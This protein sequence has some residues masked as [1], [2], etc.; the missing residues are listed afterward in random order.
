MNWNNRQGNY[1]SVVMQC[2]Q[3]FIRP[4]NLKNRTKIRPFFSKLADQNQTNF[5]QFSRN[6]RPS[7][8]KSDQNRTKI[9]V[10]NY[11]H[12]IN[13][14]R[15]QFQI[16]TWLDLTWGI[17][18]PTEKTPKPYYVKIKYEKKIGVMKMWKIRPFAQK[19]DFLDKYQTKFD[20]ISA[21]SLIIRPKSDK[22]DQ[23]GSTEIDR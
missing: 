17:M 19:S 2:F 16:K 11:N 12:Q 18:L 5:Q 20:H 9:W 15:M 7:Q 10:G 21:K 8:K 4:E 6:I 1:S 22:S 14:N 3:F 13:L 23:L